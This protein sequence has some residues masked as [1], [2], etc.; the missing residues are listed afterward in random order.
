MGMTQLLHP[1]YITNPSL[2]AEQVQRSS[3]TVGELEAVGGLGGPQPHG[4]DSGVLEAWDR[5][6]ISHG[7][8]HLEGERESLHRL[9]SC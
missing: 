5:V 7:H 8:D 4:V 6:V 9:N 3:L 2:L 1:K